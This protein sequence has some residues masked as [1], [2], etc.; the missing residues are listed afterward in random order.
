MQENLR[1]ILVS[2]PGLLPYLL[3]GSLDDEAAVIE[4]PDAR[5]QARNFVQKMG[6]EED[7]YA[8]LVEPL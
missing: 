5:A 7:G 8:S 3:L 1:K 6:G 4:N 2:L